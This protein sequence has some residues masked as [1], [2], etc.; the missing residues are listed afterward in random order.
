M[1]SMP[2]FGVMSKNGACANMPNNSWQIIAADYLFQA[3]E[4]LNEGGRGVHDHVPAA[5]LAGATLEN[6][7]R[8]KCGEQKPPIETVLPKGEKQTLSI[9]IDDLKN[10]GLYNENRAKRLR[11]W[12]R[13]SKSCGSR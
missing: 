12:A 11:A 2:H 1:K 9:L 7:M 4:L 8:S 5:V 10:A 13:N 6:R 3:D